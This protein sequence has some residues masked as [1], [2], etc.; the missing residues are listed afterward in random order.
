MATSD[1]EDVYPNPDITIDYAVDTTQNEGDIGNHYSG[2]FLSFIFPEVKPEETF[3]R[4]V[5]H[6]STST[7][8]KQVKNLYSISYEFF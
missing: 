6:T 5:F 8:L 2:I 7:S 3:T 1:D 4:D